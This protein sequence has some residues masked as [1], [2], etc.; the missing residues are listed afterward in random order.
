MVLCGF[1]FIGKWLFEKCDKKK[2]ANG[3]EITIVENDQ[4]DKT[5]NYYYGNE[6]AQYPE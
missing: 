1:A 5:N 3:N 2:K 6:T 4:K